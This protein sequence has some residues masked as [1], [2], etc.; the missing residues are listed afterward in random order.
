[1]LQPPTQLAMPLG[2]RLCITASEVLHHRTYDALD[3]VVTKLGETQSMSST[4]MLA[5]MD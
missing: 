3:C 2:M 4:A 1:M 5:C